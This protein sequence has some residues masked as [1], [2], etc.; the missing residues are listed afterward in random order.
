MRAKALTMALFIVFVAIVLFAIPFGIYTSKYIV[1]KHEQYNVINALGIADRVDS[2]LDR[3]LPFSFSIFSRVLLQTEHP[4]DY[5]QVIMPDGGIYTYGKD[6][7]SKNYYIYRV[8]TLKGALVTTKTFQYATNNEI[9]WM[10]VIIFILSSAFASF[11]IA[12]VFYV[13]HKFSVPLIYLAAQAEA[14]GAGAIR[15]QVQKSGIEEMDLVQ[16][17]LSRTAEKI[18]RRIA[19]EK[20]FA[21]NASHQLRTPL[22]AL[23]M[24]VEEIELISDSEDVKAEAAK[25]IEQIDRLT[26]IV[27]DL[28][29]S[30]RNKNITTQEAVFLYEIFDQQHK[31]WDLYF[32]RA[33]R[34]LIVIDET[35][36]AALATKGYISQVIATLIEN[37]LKYG[38]GTTTVDAYMSGSKGI[39]IDVSDEGE[40]I[41]EDISSRVFEKYFSG[42]GSSG[43]GLSIAKD[44]VEADGGRIELVSCKPPIFRISLTTVSNKF[45]SEKDL[46][47]KVMLGVGRRNRNF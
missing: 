25:C 20:Q 42:H 7:T 43:L 26:G 21:S 37:S 5:A 10:W 1:E 44:L 9:F 38:D 41:S 31:E 12:L 45:V 30:A 17:E 47:K 34:D 36:S 22:T 28:L 35:T 46:P 18:A 29:N 8:S 13:T 14:V 19:V 3:N 24:R 11:T 39:I 23:C 6:I 33:K 40:G 2:N 32:R 15:T 4:Y 16:E 27:E